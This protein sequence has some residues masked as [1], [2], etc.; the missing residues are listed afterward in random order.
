[1]DGANRKERFIIIKPNKGMKTWNQGLRRRRTYFPRL[2]KEGNLD[3]LSNSVREII[4]GILVKIV[5]KLIELK[6]KLKKHS[7]RH[8][9]V[10]KDL[11]WRIKSPKS[12]G[13]V[14]NPIFCKIIPT[15]RVLY[16]TCRTFKRPLI[17][18][19]WPEIF[20]VST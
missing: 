8:N 2:E 13:I 17:L 16:K 12:L 10:I 6:C 3:Y 9:L 5:I 14:E 7:S 11:M 1:M 20:W 15:I 19:M 18:T 4:I